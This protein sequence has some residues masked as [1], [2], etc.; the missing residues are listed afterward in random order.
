M[1]GRG[2]EPI[3]GLAS[4]VLLG[5]LGGGWLMALA[6]P[7]L[8]ALGFLPVVVVIALANGDLRRAEGLGGIAMRLAGGFAFAAPFAALALAG[9]YALGWD[10][11]VAFAGP[12]IAAGAGAGGL[13]LAR[14]GCGRLTGLLLP[15]LWSAL[16]MAGWVLLATTLAGAA[17]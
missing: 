5:G 1:S 8:L 7:L 17:A 13:D 16:T 4:L 10:A 6:A 2:G 11:G 14:A 9:R 15:G 3:A 12:A